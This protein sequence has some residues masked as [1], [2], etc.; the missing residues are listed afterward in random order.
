MKLSTL[1]EKCISIEYTQ[2]ENSAD[3]ALE[4][5]G[6]DLYIFF[7]AS[8]GSEDWKNNLEFPSRPYKRMEESTW[9]AHR[10]FSRVWKSIEGYISKDIADKKVKHITITGFSHGAAIAVLCHE[11]VWFNRPDLRDSIDGYGFGCPRVIWGFPSNEVLERWKRFT[12]IRNLDDIVTHLPPA[13]FGFS[14]VGDL[15]E[16][17]ERGRYSMIDAHRPESILAELRNRE[18]AYDRQMLKTFSLSAKWG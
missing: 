3:Y 5:T 12:V 14:H 7:E 16:I 15:I 18:R 13:L 17:G 11:Y 2:V 1:F 9:Y 4:R 10:G 6:G 8:N